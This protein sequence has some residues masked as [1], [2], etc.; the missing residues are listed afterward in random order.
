M[1]V[2][3]EAAGDYVRLHTDEKL[4]LLRETMSRMEN[5][6][7]PERFLR[8]HRSTIINT[9][10]LKELRPYGNSEYIVVLNDGT[11]L[12]L[13]RTYCDALADFFDGAL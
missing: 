9:E 6:L 8:I 10:R 7:D 2:L 1:P 11:E 5:R 4:H 12:K 3:L 13:S